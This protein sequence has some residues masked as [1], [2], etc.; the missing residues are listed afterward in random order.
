MIVQENKYGEIEYIPEMVFNPTINNKFYNFQLHKLQND[1]NE[2]ERPSRYYDDPESEH[3]LRRNQSDYD[4][5][6]EIYNQ[7]KSMALREGFQT[8]YS[9]IV[10][11]EGTE[12]LKQELQ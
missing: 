7:E 6:M 4:A 2:L 5:E 1:L 10:H 3:R 9:I 11:V 8:Q 12:A